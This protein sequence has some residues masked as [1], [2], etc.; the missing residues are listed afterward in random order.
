MGVPAEGGEGLGR[1]RLRRDV[2]RAVLLLRWWSQEADGRLRVLIKRAR[3]A[4][5]EALRL[6]STG[7]VFGLASN[8]LPRGMGHVRCVGVFAPALPLRG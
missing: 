6:T 3:R 8:Q 5:G 7:L 2:A 1:S 4:D